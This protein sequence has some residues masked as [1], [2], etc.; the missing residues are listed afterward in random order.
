[1]VYQRVIPYINVLGMFTRGFVIGVPVVITFVDYVGTVKGVTG[2]SMQPTLN[3]NPRRSS[4]VVLVNSWAVRR[5]EGIHRGDI[6]T[7]IDPTDPDAA[8]IKRVI[9]LEGDHVR[10]INYKTKIVKIPRGH[11]WVEGDNHAHSHDSNSFGPVAVGLIQGK[12]TRIVWPPRRWQRLE[13]I[14]CDERL[15]GKY[16]LLEEEKAGEH[17]IK[18][19]VDKESGTS[20]ACRSYSIVDDSGSVTEFSYDLS[21]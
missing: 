16:S 11:C 15:E 3:P 9:A 14:T 19:L 7:L 20:T 13:N 5:F 10:S 6:V 8:L 21:S 2:I 17:L 4:D 1:M 12:A 18:P